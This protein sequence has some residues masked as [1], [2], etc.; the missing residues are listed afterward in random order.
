MGSPLIATYELH[1]EVELWILCLEGVGSLGIKR[2]VYPWVIQRPT[3]VHSPNQGPR[4]DAGRVS[5][6]ICGRLVHHFTETFKKG[7]SK[8]VAVIVDGDA[9]KSVLVLEAWSL[10]DQAHMKQSLMPHAGIKVVSLTNFKLQT[11]SRSMVYFDRDV[12]NAMPRWP[13]EDAA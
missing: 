12:K 10:A 2:G 11:K 1:F 13:A 6:Q 4:D 5:E 8:S 9:L 3:G 7:S